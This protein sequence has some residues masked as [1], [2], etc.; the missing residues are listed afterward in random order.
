MAYNR[1]S[2]TEIN[3]RLQADAQSHL[4][5]YPNRRDLLQILIKVMAGASHEWYGALDAVIKQLF[6]TSAEGTYLERW[7]SIFGL[8]RR[9]ATK[10]HGELTLT[11]SAS[12]VEVPVGTVFIAP[13]GQSYVTSGPVS[14]E[15]QVAVEAVNAGTASTVAVGT[16]MTLTSPVS[17]VLR[18]TVVS[19]AAGTDDESDADLRARLLFRTQN[20]P[21]GGTVADYVSWALE[22]PGVTRAWC[23][24][25]TPSPG[26]VTV[27]FMTDGLTEDGIPS[28][29]SVS[30][31][32]AYLATVAP[33]GAV[34]H[35]LQP[36]KQ[37]LNIHVSGLQPDNV[38]LR[39]QIISKLDEVI[40]DE[41]EPGHILYR[42]HLSSAIASL[43]DVISHE[44]TQ[45]SAEVI[46]PTKYN[47]FMLGEVTFDGD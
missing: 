38:T 42:S 15:G 32:S 19:M 35:V 27:R 30:A 13:G 10:A 39:Q 4:A 3:D 44:I 23:Y 24:A 33:I 37:L 7:A 1:P 5:A 20:P 29:E 45:P 36:V 43:P 26:E 12:V 14:P 18:G 25:N 16:E 34:V 2:L 8:Q 22:V 6:W 11:F 41:A 31:V 17:G 46:Q 28:E 21:R 9:L 47:L 40:F